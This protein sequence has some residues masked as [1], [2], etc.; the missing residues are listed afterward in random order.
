MVVIGGRLSSQYAQYG[1]PGIDT[2]GRKNGGRTEQEKKGA[3]FPPHQ[4]FRL[5]AQSFFLRNEL[6][7]TK[8]W[9]ILLIESQ[10]Y[11]YAEL[12]SAIG[13]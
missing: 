5:L 12:R 2:Q 8:S 1:I 11:N 10:K 9:L 7:T 13:T 6:L 3:S 4:K